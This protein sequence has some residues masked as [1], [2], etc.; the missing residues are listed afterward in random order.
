METVGEAGS[1]APAAFGA[2]DDPAVPHST[3]PHNKRRPISP[4][5]LNLSP[6]PARSGHAC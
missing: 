6:P 4:L 5:R 2:D 1:T 3:V